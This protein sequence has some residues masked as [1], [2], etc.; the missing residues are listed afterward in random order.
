MERKTVINDKL[1]SILACPA[2]ED[3]PPVKLKDN[4]LVC[5]KCKRAYPIRDGIPVM[6]VDEAEMGE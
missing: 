2:C 4:V 6:L 5:E 1:L 3:R